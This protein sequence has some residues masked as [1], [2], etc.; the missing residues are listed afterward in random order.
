MISPVLFN[1]MV[2]D[3]FKQVEDKIGLSLL[4]SNEALWKCRQ[5]VKYVFRQLQSALNKVKQWARKLRLR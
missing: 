1:N 2:N 4:G 3:I 5:N